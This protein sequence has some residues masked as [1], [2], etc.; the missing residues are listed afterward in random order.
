MRLPL[1]L[2]A[3]TLITIPLRAAPPQPL[4]AANPFFSPWRTP[5]GV[6]PFDR[7]KDDHFLP[8]F[9]EGM[10][11]QRKELA[12]IAGNKAAPTFRNTL[13]ALDASG[14][15]LAQVSNVFFSLAS[16]ETNERL[17]AVES[18]VGPLLAAHQ[19]S[20]YMDAALFLRVKAVFDQAAHLK[21]TPEQRTLLG[22]T[23]RRFNRGGA[24]LPPEGQARLRAINGELATL[25]S[26]FSANL[27]KETNAFQLVVERTQ[28]L[29]GLPE[30]QIAAAAAAA[31]QAGLEGKWVFTLKAP[32][33]WPFLQ[34]AQNR[35]LRRQLLAGYTNRCDHGGATDNKTTFA[36]IAA[37]RVEKAQLLGFKTWA[38][39]Q[40][41]ENMAKTPQRAYQLLEQV[42][43]P[44]L[45]A[46]KRERAELQAMMD[47]DLPGQK[48]EAADWRYYSDQV[49]KARFDLDEQALRPYFPLDRVREGAFQVA[50]KLYG[51]TFTERK[52]LPIYNPEVKT[53]EVK[54]RLGKHVGILYVDYHPRP[55]KQGGAWCVSYVDP[56]RRDGKRVAP[57]LVNVGNFARPVGAAPALLSPDEV[58]TLFHEFGHALHGLFADYTYRS[59]GNNAIDFVEM[60][61]QIMENWAQEPE[62]LKLYARH[63]Q[64]GAVIPDALVKKIQE[65]GKFNQ[66]FITTEF[67]AAVLLDLDWHT[68]TDT[69]P[70]E[71]AAFERASLA[72][73]G[74]IPEIVSRYRTPYFAHAAGEYSAG[75][76]SYLWSAVLDSDAF[77]AFKEKGNL[78]D[79]ATAKALHLLLSKGGSEDPAELYR[80]FR[81]RDPKVEALLQKRGLN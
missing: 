38:E 75:Y 19:D 69:K 25:G 77:Q 34:Y 32:S 53:F 72:K 17:Q 78:F 46:A 22:A 26:R 5:F 23:Y 43:Q 52:D 80:T 37:L 14:L 44:A 1:F 29:A 71:A 12:A 24:T 79:P 7:I 2:V 27:L 48:L 41:A 60:P 3:A 70:R 33:L 8:A 49:K 21:L 81:G 13:E 58:R 47:R 61:S 50:G 66:G 30:S 6:P 4:P 63:Y 28:D 15:F 40:L 39:F 31:K 59:S 76:Y 67:M 73:W 36:Q 56:F 65:A 54:D 45:E 11:R 42:W 55:G 18:E 9:R 20:V 16:A 68:L 62:V 64:T 10:A 35:E 57:V 51:I 74:L